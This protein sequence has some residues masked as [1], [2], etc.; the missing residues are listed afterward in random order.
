MPD[1]SYTGS[2]VVRTGGCAD[3]KAIKFI[4][5]SFRVGDRAFIAT[6]ARRGYLEP[7]FIKEVIAIRSEKTFNQ[8]L[9]KYKDTFNGIHFDGDL[10]DEYNA[11]LVAE[12]YLEARQAEIDAKP[13]C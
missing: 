2:G 9:V 8:Y 6:S 5:V 7:V 13:S 10:F 11:L 1:F 12:A 3:T 4:T